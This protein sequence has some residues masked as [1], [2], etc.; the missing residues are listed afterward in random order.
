[1]MDRRTIKLGGRLKSMSIASSANPA[2]AGASAD[3]AGAARSNALPS[4]T[5]GRD[6]TSSA[7]DGLL[8]RQCIG[9]FEKLI[10][11]LRLREST[12][13]D[14]LAQATVEL[15]VTLAERL[16]NEAIAADRQRL[17]CVVRDAL[18]RLQPARKVT[19]SGHA[20]D[21]ALLQRQ[22]NEDVPSVQADLAF[23]VE[24]GRMRGQ[25]KI[26]TEDLFVDFDPQR[27]LNELRERLLEETFAD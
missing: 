25:L 19:I 24:K 12:T 10:A 5:D 9:E 17:D 13:I 7:D 8:L 1:M 22:L 4:P 26:E 14:S 3:A 21:I 20:D 27:S 2:S 11:K 6:E 23:R 15:A 16:M 18:E